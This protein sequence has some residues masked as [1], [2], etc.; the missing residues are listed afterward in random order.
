MIV[1]IKYLR[2]N[3]M[4]S[5][6]NFRELKGF[7]TLEGT[8][9]K[10][11]MFYRSGEVVG[12]SDEDRVRFSEEY[13]IKH[14]YDFRN[15]QEVG[16]RPDDKIKGTQYH[17]IDLMKDAG[18]GASLE[19]FVKASDFDANAAMLDIYEKTLLSPSG[20]NGFATFFEDV[21][22]HEDESVLFHCFAGKDRT[23]MAAGLILS[24]LDV[25][26]KDIMDDYLLTNAA[27]K[28][29]NDAL[30][31]MLAQ[32]GLGKPQLKSIETMMYVKP[33]YL[34]HGYDTLVKHYG[35]VE[36]YFVDRDGLNIPKNSIVDM[37]RLYTM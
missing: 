37:K 18:A 19:D 28:T 13:K 10:P 29:A 25:N 21:L 35:N 2:G 24:A 9:V 7:K 12:L 34:E 23:G 6:V 33:D 17:H 1:V 36:N 26:R 30:I 14:I 15:D 32:K 3:S 27:R 4:K 11:G 5:L 16:E 31:A 20:R 22:S 8:Q